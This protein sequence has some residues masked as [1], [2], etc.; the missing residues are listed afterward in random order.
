MPE[1]RAHPLDVSATPTVDD[2]PG[3]PRWLISAP[4]EMD[5][6]ALVANLLRRGVRPYVVTDVAVPGSD[7][8]HNVQRAIRQADRVLVVLSKGGSLNPVFEAGV[9][10]SLDKPLLIIAPPDVPL[11]ALL[12]GFLTVRA[13]VDDLD[14][15]NFALDHSEALVGV[16]SATH[17]KATS[18]PLGNRADEFRDQAA[19]LV[20]S[21]D[22][23]DVE[24]QVVQ[25]LAEAL[26]LSGAVTATD[27]E[28]PSFRSD[29]AIWLDDLDAIGANPF[30]VEI[31][32][33]FRA[34]AVQQL[35]RI[36][37]AA[38]V[39]RMA[40]I[41]YLNSASARPDELT[42]VAQ[43]PVLAI[44]LDEL[45]RRMHSQSFAEVVLD[46]RNRSVHGLPLS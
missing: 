46:L 43:F 2:I 13:H 10:V 27:V 26:E 12:A 4:A 24:R 9:A 37:Q 30:F 34:E 41:V 32:R 15:I 40:L 16:A 28:S 44:S 45:L 14:A 19:R 38:P 36:V 23:S 8:L 25:L 1:R 11:P 20:A 35:L 3:P 22:Q 18:V 6:R 31:K 42:R 33:S 29:M 17:T 39:A 21:D 7:L 5:V